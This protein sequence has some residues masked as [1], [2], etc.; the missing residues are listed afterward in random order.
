MLGKIQF[1]LQKLIDNYVCN[2][3]FH[4]F[5]FNFLCFS[6]LFFSTLFQRSH[7][8]QTITVPSESLL[9]E[10]RIVEVSFLTFLSF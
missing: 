1:K 6:L 8:I 3:L 7:I 5:F 9:N 2:S 10:L 4:P